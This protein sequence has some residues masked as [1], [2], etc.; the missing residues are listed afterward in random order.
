MNT[1]Y[2]IIIG[3]VILIFIGFTIGCVVYRLHKDVDESLRLIHS[4]AEDL[5]AIAKDIDE[6]NRILEDKNVKL[7]NM[8]R[9]IE[10]KE[11]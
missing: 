10:E 5:G 7:D 3:T 9:K 2:Y 4:A 11:I 6:M 8:I 1:V